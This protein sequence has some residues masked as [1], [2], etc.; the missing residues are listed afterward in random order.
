MKNKKL[1]SVLVFIGVI[2]L[3]VFLFYQAFVQ[4]VVEILPILQH[5]DVEEIAGYLRAS[6]SVK[7]LIA[8]IILQMIQVWTIIIS[9]IPI[10]VAAG[11]VY[12]TPK[13][14]ITC[15]LA[16]VAAMTIAMC[17]YRRAHNRLDEWFP[18]GSFI[19]KYIERIQSMN[20]PPRYTTVLACMIP[21]VPNG[22]IPIVAARMDIT[23]KEFAAATWIGCFPNILICCAIGNRLIKGDFTIALL[24]F[25]LMIG[26]VTLLWV[27]RDQVLKI[28]RY[29]VHDVLH[30]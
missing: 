25:L 14:F 8:T 2:A 30:L 6:N 16:T 9:G 23:P 13:A 15:H 5:A 28:L 20:T 19:W 22:I 7:G 3:A 4:T 17:G 18:K 12:G 29:I 26:M 10:Q 27:F 1:L 21:A 24:Y 11:V